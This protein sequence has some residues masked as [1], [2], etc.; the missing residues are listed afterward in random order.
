MPYQQGHAPWL[1]SHQWKKVK[2]PKSKILGCFF[3]VFKTK[4]QLLDFNLFYLILCMYKYYNN[5]PKC[6]RN[7]TTI[8]FNTGFQISEW[9]PTFPDSTGR[10]YGSPNLPPCA[11]SLILFPSLSHSFSL[12]GLVFLGHLFLASTA[13]ALVVH[14]LPEGQGG[15]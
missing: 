13:A 15:M 12:T 6:C 3:L 7:T 14:P 11:S 4:E 9:I 2:F 10:S 8:S 1:A 5:N